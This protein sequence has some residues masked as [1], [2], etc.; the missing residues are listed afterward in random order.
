PEPSRQAA[1]TA[2]RVGPLMS[3][4]GDDRPSRDL[5]RIHELTEYS[6]AGGELRAVLDE[7][8]DQ[9]LELLAADTAAVLLLE[10]SGR[11]LVATAARGLEEEVRQ[12]VRVPVSHGFA[13]RVASEHRPVVLDEV[14]PDNVWNPVLWE[15]G[16][17]AMLGVPVTDGRDV[18]GVLHV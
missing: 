1:R 2:P 11:E 6:L 12:G 13:G 8:L 10:P 17:R 9:T 14:R 5:T 15:E 4:S 16:I 3:A 7:V 18:V